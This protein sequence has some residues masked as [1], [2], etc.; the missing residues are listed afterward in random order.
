MKIYFKTITVIKLVSFSLFMYGFVHELNKICGCKKPKQG[1]KK[2]LS[3]TTIQSP[4]I[5]LSLLTVT[6]FY[7]VF[8]FIKRTTKSA[9]SV[10][11]SKRYNYISC[12][13]VADNF[14]PLLH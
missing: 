10:D 7:S 6:R 12:S 1:C 14:T 8:L 5:V 2:S 11:K 4:T 13:V 9:D 3:T